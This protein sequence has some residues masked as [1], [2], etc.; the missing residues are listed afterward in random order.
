MAGCDENIYRSTRGVIEQKCKAACGIRYCH[1]L[2]QG[3]YPTPLYE[4]AISFIGLGLLWIWRR[5]IR[6]GGMVFALYLM[7]N[8]IERFFIEGIR[9][10]PRYPEYGFNWSQAQYISVLFVLIG[11]V[12]AIYLWKKGK[13]YYPKDQIGA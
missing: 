13:R 9:V 1:E 2:P 6:I 8:G 12:M 3:V 10:N 4:I 5:K 7:Y 11:F